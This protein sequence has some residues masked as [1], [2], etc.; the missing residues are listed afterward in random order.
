[1]PSRIALYLTLLAFLISAC[2][3]SKGNT[4][5]TLAAITMLPESN[6]G[7]D[8]QFKSSSGGEP[9]SS[10]YWLIWNTCA[11]GNQSEIARANGGREAGWILMD[12]LLADPGV[13]IG[14]LQI[15]TC[16]Q[17]L[18]LLQSRNLQNNDMK[19]D[20]AYNLAAQLLA[21]Q[22]NLAS[23]SE[24][25]PASDQAVSEAQLLLLELNFDGTGS[26]LGPPL[27][28]SKMDN[29]RELIEQLASYNSGTLCLP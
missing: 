28:S 16:Q 4:P 14:T 27:A 10:G 19:S 11:E 22:L 8:P 3:T 7:Q 12:D 26:Y 23:G 18:S 24:Y 6:Q 13:L 17:G 5:P 1:M 21:A 29:A 20:A 9:R 15:E 2:T 25:C